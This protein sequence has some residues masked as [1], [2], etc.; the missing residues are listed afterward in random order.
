FLVN[1]LNNLPNILNS[2]NTE[3]SDLN[4]IKKYLNSL[5]NRA[6]VSH[7]EFTHLDKWLDGL[8]I[9]MYKETENK[10]L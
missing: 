1:S 4:R 5:K 3:I 10:R 6:E 9:E 7:L 2:R 8:Q